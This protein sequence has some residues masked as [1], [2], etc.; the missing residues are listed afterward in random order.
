MSVDQSPP[1]R[2]RDAKHGGFVE[3]KLIDRQRWDEDRVGPFGALVDEAEAHLAACRSTHSEREGEF[4]EAKRAR[5]EAEESFGEDRVPWS[6]V[7]AA[8]E[9]ESKARA[10]LNVARLRWTPRFTR[11]RRRKNAQ[12]FRSLNAA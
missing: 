8:L 10:R 6:K 3:A 1:K 9:L 11:R 12:P 2:V 7:T 4:H 5:E